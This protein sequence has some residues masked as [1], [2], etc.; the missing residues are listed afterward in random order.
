MSKE[1]AINTNRLGQDISSMQDRLNAVKNEMGTMYDAVRALNAS[2]EGPA[3]SEF[4]AQFATD[5][6]AMSE[7]CDLVSEL[8]KCVEYAKTEYEK[9]ENE[10]NSIVTSIR[11]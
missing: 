8:I 9:C 2:W 6:Q 3:H 5:E 4:L 11:V 1:I 10:V 7:F